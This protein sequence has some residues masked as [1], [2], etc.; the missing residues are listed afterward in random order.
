M[1]YMSMLSTLMGQAPKKS[2]SKQQGPADLYEQALTFDVNGVKL[3]YK[4]GYGW[5]SES[6]DIVEAADELEKALDQT[7]MLELENE[8]LRAELTESNDLRNIAMAMLMEEKTKRVALEKELEA[9]REELT[10]AYA[11]VSA[12]EKLRSLVKGSA[13]TAKK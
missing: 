3:N 8:D 11:T 5:V 10:K 7:D 1:L 4:T 13:R 6:N 9:Y 2:V 12:Q